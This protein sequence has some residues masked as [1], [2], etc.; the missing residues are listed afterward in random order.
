MQLHPARDFET[1]EIEVLPLMAR[2]ASRTYPDLEFERPRA[3]MWLLSFHA[4]DAQAELHWFAPSVLIALRKE[5]FSITSSVLWRVRVFADEKTS[6]A[7][8]LSRLLA[9]RDGPVIVLCEQKMRGAFLGDQYRL[10][11]QRKVLSTL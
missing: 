8:H 5:P 11:P 7:G 1:I 9:S 10:S 6:V 4:P 3:L 2:V